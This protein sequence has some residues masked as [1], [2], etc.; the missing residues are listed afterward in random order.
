[1][2]TLSLSPEFLQNLILRTRA[3]MA[4]DG[5]IADDEGNFVDDRD[6]GAPR[7]ETMDLSKAELAGKIDDLEPDQQAELVALMWIGRG[8]ME[9]EEWDSAVAL[10][11]ERRDSSTAEYLLSHPQVAEHW[12][13]ALDRLFDGSNVVEEGEF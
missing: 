2:E 12:D 6:P 9:P 13:E 11:V 8:D 4:H 1:M 5:A 10:A 7:Y 3:L